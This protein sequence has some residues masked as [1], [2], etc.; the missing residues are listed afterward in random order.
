MMIRI[1]A[2]ML[3]LLLAACGKQGEPSPPGPAGAVTWPHTYPSH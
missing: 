3:L 1:G 2:V